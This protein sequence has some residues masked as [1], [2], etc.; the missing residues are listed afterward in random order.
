MGSYKNKNTVRITLSISKVRIYQ[1][2]EVIMIQL[3][4]L[5]EGN[6]IHSR[7]YYNSIIWSIGA[8]YTFNKSLL[9]LWCPPLIA[10][11]L[12]LFCSLYSPDSSFQTFYF[13]VLLKGIQFRSRHM[14]AT[15]Y[16]LISSLLQTTSFSATSWC[17]YET[18]K[19]M[20]WYLPHRTWT[21]GLW[22]NYFWCISSMD[23]CINTKK[24]HF[25]LIF[26]YIVSS[27]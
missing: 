24:V 5:A 4:F 21:L 10:L 15:S 8:P 13:L 14:K 22:C 16:I 12:T 27:S 19:V 11:L 23:S 6:Y 20:E 2:I 25:L 18:L 7:S 17:I 3:L 9:S 1:V 26:E